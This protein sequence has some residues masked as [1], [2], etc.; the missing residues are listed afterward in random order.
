MPPAY[1]FER[2][3]LFFKVL[4][5]LCKVIDNSTQHVNRTKHVLQ[6]L[7]QKCFSFAVISL[8]FSVMKFFAL[9]PKDDKDFCFCS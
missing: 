7:Q 5:R 3:A 4:L 6:E 1:L 2:I 8:R 9:F